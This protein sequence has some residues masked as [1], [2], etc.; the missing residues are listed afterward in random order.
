MTSGNYRI[1][2]P[3]AAQTVTPGMAMWRGFRGHCPNCDRGRMFRKFLK[4]ANACPACGE[5]L[6]HH[7]ADD[8]PAYLDIVLV[9]HVLVPIVLLVETEM[10]PPMWVSMT[11]WPLIGLAMTLSLLQPLKGLVVGLQWA[12]GMHGFEQSK[13]ARQSRDRDAAKP[14]LPAESLPGASLPDPA[15][16]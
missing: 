3:E 6:S 4:V 10:P 5:E 13:T 14:D 8:F 11:M 15:S 2:T 12:L 7:R 9:G 16:N 1:I